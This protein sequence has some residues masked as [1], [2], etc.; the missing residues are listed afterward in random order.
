MSS[1]PPDVMLL[2]AEWPERALV[3]AQLLEEGYEVVAI[4][5]WPM[6]K[7]Y[8]RPG[9]KPRLLIIDLRGL[10]DPRDVLDDARFVLPADRV[11]IITALGTVPERDVRELGYCVIPRPAT[12]ETIVRTAAALLTRTTLPKTS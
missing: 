3:R 2:G 6:P 11:L 5:T 8:R 12:V 1:Q 4:D 7:F 9:M 10:P